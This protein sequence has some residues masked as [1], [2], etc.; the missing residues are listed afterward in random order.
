MNLSDIRNAQNNLASI[1][2]AAFHAIRPASVLKSMR[3]SRSLVGN[4]QRSVSSEAC[5][6]PQMENEARSLELR[7]RAGQG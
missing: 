7:L 2:A 5:N 1:V 6:D 4:V 3:A